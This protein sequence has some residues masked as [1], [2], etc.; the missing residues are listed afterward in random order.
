ME[1][2]YVG[3]PLERVSAGMELFRVV[4]D[5]WPC[6]HPASLKSSTRT[7]S[8]GSSLLT[9]DSVS[10]DSFAASVRDRLVQPD[11]CHVFSYL[12]SHSRDNVR[13]AAYAVALQIGPHLL[14]SMDTS[15]AAYGHRAHVKAQHGHL[16]AEVP[17]SLAPADLSLYPHLLRHALQLTARVR[18]REFDTG[19]LIV[20]LLWAA[21]LGNQQQSGQAT[22]S[23]LI[24][25]LQWFSQL[26]DHA[27][28]S[29]R[30]GL[31]RALA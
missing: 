15:C 6:V 24:C 13:A 23:T 31:I 28:E 17:L 27:N 7:A 29:D 4:S 12:L 11:C 21:V 26:L 16:A 30:H 2:M 8:P 19:A 9:A 10:S 14:I 20:R 1:N 3:T 5:L 22:S 18:E 25:L